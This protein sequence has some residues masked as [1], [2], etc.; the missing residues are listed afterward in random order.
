MFMLDANTLIAL[1]SGEPDKL[2][3]R[4]SACDEGDLVI[5]AIAFAEVALG[6]WQGRRPSL[7][8]L[9]QLP[10][11]IAVLP[12]D[13]RAAKRYAQL[14]VRRGSY[15]RL[16]AAHALALNLTLVTNNVRDFADIPGLR[17]ENWTL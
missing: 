4:A 7:I 5:S 1:L 17:V 3:E 16:I 15:D 11:R 12:F 9:D 13:H 10:G 6:S 8:V 14:P 2:G